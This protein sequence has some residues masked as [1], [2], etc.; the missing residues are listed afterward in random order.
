MQHDPGAG[1]GAPQA[2]LRGETASERGKGLFPEAFLCESI[3]SVL[4]V[5][6]CLLGRARKEANR[7]ES[8]LLTVELH[9]HLP[10]VHPLITRL[11]SKVKRF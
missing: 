5:G 10:K 4:A 3:T 7:K 8:T 6:F 1:T 9:F 2:G 11:I